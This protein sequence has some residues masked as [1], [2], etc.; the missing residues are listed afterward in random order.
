M[1]DVHHF[2]N[3]QCCLL[4]KN[5]YL[6]LQLAT[7]LQKAFIVRNTICNFMLI[8]SCLTMFITTIDITFSVN[9]TV[10]ILLD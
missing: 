1:S 10:N 4:L 9:Q 3:Y 5:K 7:F 6:Q 8:E 2:F